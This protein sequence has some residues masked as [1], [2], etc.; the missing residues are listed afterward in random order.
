M[1]LAK[2]VAFVTAV[3]ED[4]ELSRRMPAEPVAGPRPDP[5]TTPG[6]NVDT[7]HG[8]LHRDPRL[9]SRHQV[10]AAHQMDELRIFLPAAFFGKIQGIDPDFGLSVHGPTAFLPACIPGL[11]V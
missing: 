3:Y 4:P 7:D 8:V 6:R 1:H 2:H 9:V 11:S 5:V 10:A